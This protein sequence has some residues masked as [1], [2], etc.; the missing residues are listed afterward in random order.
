MHETLR[1]IHLKNGSVVFLVVVMSSICDLDE[2]GLN[3][4]KSPI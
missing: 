1:K 3:L 4:Q 2:K